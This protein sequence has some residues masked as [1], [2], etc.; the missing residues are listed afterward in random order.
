MV[1]NFNI[2]VALMTLISAGPP[3]TEPN[4]EV[5]F[6]LSS[7]MYIAFPP[8]SGLAGEIKFE[9]ADGVNTFDVTLGPYDNYV[10]LNNVLAPSLYQTQNLGY[11]RMPL[12]PLKALGFNGFTTVL[13]VTNTTNTNFQIMGYGSVIP[14]YYLPG[15]LIP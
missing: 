12:T 15:G 13:R 11:V 4:A 5:L 14:A 3:V 10:T 9:W 7:V 2:P 1:T 6:D 8:S